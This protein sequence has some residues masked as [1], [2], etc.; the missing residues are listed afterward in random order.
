MGRM[1]MKKFSVPLWLWNAVLKDDAVLMGI[2]NDNQR[3]Q[4]IL[5]YYNGRVKNEKKAL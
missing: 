2:E 4:T 5:F 1:K 3:L